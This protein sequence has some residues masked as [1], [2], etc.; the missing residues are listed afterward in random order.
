LRFFSLRDLGR[1]PQNLLQA[2]INEVV[3]FLYFKKSSENNLANFE[4][5]LDIFQ[6]N[7]LERAHAKGDLATREV[8]SAKCLSKSTIKGIHQLT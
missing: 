4:T 1:K 2:T 3:T 5:G 6:Q 7:A 8:T